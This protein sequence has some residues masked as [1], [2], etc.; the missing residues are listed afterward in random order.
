MDENRTTVPS[1]TSSL[2]RFQPS[3]RRLRGEDVQPHILLRIQVPSVSLSG[4]IL[5]KSGSMFFVGGPNPP[6][7]ASAGSLLSGFVFLIVWTG[8]C[9]FPVT[10]VICRLRCESLFLGVFGV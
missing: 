1:R 5:V 4:S 2:P 9:L 3:T 8:L 10:V 6:S 7:Q